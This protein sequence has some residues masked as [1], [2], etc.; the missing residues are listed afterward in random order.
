MM[1]DLVE[2]LDDVAIQNVAV[3]YATRKARLPEQPKRLS[4]EEW[5]E[6]CDRCHGVDGDSKNPKF[7]ILTGQSA[8]YLVQA[9][10]IYHAERRTSSVMNAMSFPLGEAEFRSLAAHYAGKRRH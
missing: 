4:T 7:P 8:E 2:P 3:F 6:R 9:L 1:T 10:R 5:A